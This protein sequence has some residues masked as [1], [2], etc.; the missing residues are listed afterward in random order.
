MDIY[1][2]FRIIG[3]VA[4]HVKLLASFAGVHNIFH[5]FMLRKSVVDLK[6]VV[7][8]IELE[9]SKDMTYVIRPKTIR[10]GL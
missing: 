5:V 10:I 8:P 4:Y 7:T 2:I 6:E 1:P 9:I 3:P